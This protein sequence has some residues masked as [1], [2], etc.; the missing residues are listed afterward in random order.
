MLAIDK[1]VPKI[2][3]PR[4]LTKYLE[5]QI[6]VIRRRTGVWKRK[7]EDRA[8]ILEGLRKALDFS[9]TI[10]A[11]IRGHD[12]EVAKAQL[13]ERFEFSPFRPKQSDMRL[14]CFWLVWNVR[15]LKNITI[16]LNTCQA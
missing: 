12:T 8:H 9:L 13:I 2:M 14:A 1:G 11:I 3:E 16:L 7:A 10:I 5:Y 4:L 6:E 15:R